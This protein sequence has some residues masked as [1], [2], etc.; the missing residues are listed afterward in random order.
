MIQVLS[1]AA[2]LLLWLLVYDLDVVVR[3]L[4]LFGELEVVLDLSQDCG[5]GGG[6][7]ELMVVSEWVGGCD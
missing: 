1:L 6:R 2:L 5:G 4:G 3:V 7:C